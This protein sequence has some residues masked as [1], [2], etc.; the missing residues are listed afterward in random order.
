VPGSYFPRDQNTSGWGLIGGTSASSPACAAV[1]SQVNDFLIERGDKPLGF[2][3]PLCVAS[4]V[5]RRQH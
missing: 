1:F 5:C 2:M 3:N 4:P